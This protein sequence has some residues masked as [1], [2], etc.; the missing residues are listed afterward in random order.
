MI[1][2]R[3]IAAFVLLWA[4]PCLA[5][6]GS[7]KTPAQLNAEINQTYPDN[8]VGAITPFG[9]RQVSLDQVASFTPISP[10]VCFIIS[11]TATTCNNGGSSANNGTYTLPTG[12]KWIT[13]RM[14]GG[15]AGGAGGG[16]G[17]PGTGVAG[18]NTTFGTALLTANGGAIQANPGGTATGGYDNENGG[19]G[20]AGALSGTN[21]LGGPGGVSACGFGSSSFG[22]ANG[23]PSGPGGKG[24]G[25]GGGGSSSSATPGAG[26]SAGGCLYALI[27]SPAATYSYA[28]AAA[29]TAGIAGTNGQAGI[30][31]TGGAI[32]VIAYFQ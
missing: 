25:G 22:V 29:G 17:S 8:G 28:I 13:V 4:F 27:T 15:G 11:T 30:A 12:A 23:T 31:G 6:T 21:G 2:R 14:A 16:S 3:I 24:N 7:V 19:A 10:V 9:L 18:G 1:L 20:G 32:E 26:G 5:Q